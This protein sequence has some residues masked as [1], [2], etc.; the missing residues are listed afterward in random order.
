MQDDKNAQTYELIHE[1]RFTFLKEQ[2]SKLAIPTAAKV[3]DVGCYPPIILNFLKEK[4]FETYGISSQHEQM[5]EKNIKVLNIETERFPWKDNSF[6]LVVMTEVIEHLPHSPLTVLKELNRVLAP[7][8]YMIITT[9]NAVKLHNRLR[10]LM[11]KSIS[12]PVEQLLTVSPGNGSLYHLHNR[13][14]TLSEL[15]T[16]LVLADF[17]IFESRQVC[18]YPPTRRKVRQEPLSA[19]AVKWA[20]YLGQQLA[21][22][23]KDSLFVVARK[24]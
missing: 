23:F 8:G 4:G 13:E 14:Y 3:L 18:L 5:Q 10:V 12:F 21:P 6:Q 1:Y 17:E 20:G 24:K 16:L 7:G 15:E 9:P 11:G 22:G 19:Q 2:I